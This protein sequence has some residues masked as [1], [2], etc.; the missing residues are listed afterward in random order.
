MN[1]K[2]K[3]YTTIS[4]MLF[5]LKCTS[6]YIPSL[7]M[8]AVLS[9]AVK[10]AIPVLEIYIPKIVI[11]EITTAESWQKLVAALLTVTLLL[12]LLGAFSKFCERCIYD[13]KN[14]I[15]LYYIRKISF[16][17]LTTDYANRETDS[18]RTLQQESCIISAG[19]TFALSSLIM[20]SLYGSRM[21]F[22]CLP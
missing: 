20:K 22:P 15:G 16:K 7:L 3:T 9:I 17:G 8:W 1:Y 6:E 13:R 10:T 2:P 14:M 11:I 18:F 12:A 5:C 4:N 21:L 19:C